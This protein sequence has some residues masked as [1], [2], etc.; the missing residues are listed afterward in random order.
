MFINRFSPRTE[1]PLAQDDQVVSDGIAL[2]LA[3]QLECALLACDS[4]CRL[5]HA[6]RAG[7]RAMASGQMLTLVG[8]RIHCALTSQGEWFDAVRDAAVHR[9]CRLLWIGK[10]G[11]STMVVAMPIV[12]ER[13]RM[14]MAV[15]SLGRRSACSRLG[16]E[17]LAARYQLTFAER[18]VFDALLNNASPR[19]I[20]AAHGVT[21]TT[22]RTQIQAVRDKLGVRTTGALLLRAAE[23]PPVGYWH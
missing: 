12:I 23:L 18:R 10:P 6:N 16:M 7:H 2:A 5:L 4:E 15:I 14:P 9:R 11:A 19:E 3:D 21:V 1:S 13:F 8:G 17:L 22:I 20:A